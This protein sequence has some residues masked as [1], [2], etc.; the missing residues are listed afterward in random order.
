MAAWRLALGTTARRRRAD[1]SY[2]E[3]EHCQEHED[4]LTRRR[5]EVQV[6][7]PAAEF[8]RRRLGAFWALPAPRWSGPRR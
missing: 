6:V 3:G 4:G 8:Q 2:S 7:E 5:R 1:C